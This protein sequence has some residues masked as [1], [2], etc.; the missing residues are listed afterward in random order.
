MFPAYR[1]W[2]RKNVVFIELY[3]SSTFSTPD[4]LLFSFSFKAT[5]E[6]FGIDTFMAFHQASAIRVGSKLAQLGALLATNSFIL[7]KCKFFERSTCCFP[8]APQLVAFFPHNSFYVP[9]NETTRWTVK[10]NQ[11]SNYLK[12]LE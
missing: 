2:S 1:R 6:P 11:R 8:P 7:A 5:E 4:L 12:W 9:S 10:R 3:T